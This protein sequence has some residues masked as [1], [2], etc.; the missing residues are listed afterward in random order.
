M[1]SCKQASQLVSQ[2]LERKLNW[3]ERMAL[4]LHLWMCKYCRRFGQQL[5]AFRV[6]LIRMVREMENNTQIT[7]PT[8]SKQSIAN[9]INRQHL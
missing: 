1:L 5:Q 8:E 4:R 7:L 2:S 6:M 3:Q 9:L